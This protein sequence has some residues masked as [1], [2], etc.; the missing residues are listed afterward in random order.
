VEMHRAVVMPV[1]PMLYWIENTGISGEDV[2]LLCPEHPVELLIAVTDLL[3]RGFTK[4]STTV[5]LPGVLDILA[6]LGIHIFVEDLKQG[7]TDTAV[8]NEEIHRDDDYEVNNNSFG[9]SAIANPRESVEPKSHTG[10]AP[11]KTRVL[12]KNEAKEISR[13]ANN[14][15]SDV[16]LDMTNKEVHKNVID[17]IGQDEN[18]EFGER[19]TTKKKSCKKLY[20]CDFCEF[21]CRFLKDLYR[22]CELVHSGEDFVCDECNYKY[23]NFAYLRAHKKRRHTGTLSDSK[24]SSKKEVVNYILDERENNR[25]DECGDDDIGKDAVTM[26][27][28][29]NEFL[30]SIP[31]E[32]EA[33]TESEPVKATASSFDETKDCRVMLNN[34]DN[35]LK[36]MVNVEPPVYDEIVP[37]ADVSMCHEI[38]ESNLYQD[39]SDDSKDVSNQDCGGEK[40]V[41]DDTRKAEL[42]LNENIK[43]SNEN[44]VEVS[45]EPSSEDTSKSDDTETVVKPKIETECE[46]KLRNDCR[47][48][49]VADGERYVSEPSLTV[50]TTVV[51][52]VDDEMPGLS[53]RKRKREERGDCPLCGKEFG[54]KV[55]E[56][57]AVRCKGIL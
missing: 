26:L 4:T 13:I 39:D 8:M 48:D 55:L 10:I 12:K 17:E 14:K 16:S 50:S 5:T 31:N 49:D 1:S 32:N 53:K 46:S 6:C 47:A 23:S 30:R 29:A 54:L 15:V 44:V 9:K 21:Y 37:T 34:I 7:Q 43:Q 35:L 20:K 33:Y 2:V 52:A 40:Q 41:T 22:H 11:S 24:V 36:E 28:A 42:K 25:E 18:G 38:Q 3:Y 27:K 57:H 19:T 56:K 45:E 51:T